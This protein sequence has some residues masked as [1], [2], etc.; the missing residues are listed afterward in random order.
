MIHKNKRGDFPSIM[1]ETGVFQ[2]GTVL[3]KDLSIVPT[4]CEHVAMFLHVATPHPC[5]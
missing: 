4:M 5:L 1:M 2:I 3:D